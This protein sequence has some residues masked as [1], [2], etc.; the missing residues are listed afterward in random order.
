M[1]LPCYSITVE[2]AFK[3]IY[4]CDRVDWAMAFDVEPLNCINKRGKRCNE[5][6]VVHMSMGEPM[7]TENQSLMHTHMVCMVICLTVI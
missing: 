3:C 2:N 1:H 5:E 6:I 4:A 7:P